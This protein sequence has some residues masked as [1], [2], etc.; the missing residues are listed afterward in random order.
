MRGWSGP[1]GLHWSRLRL[2]GG[3]GGGLPSSLRTCRSPLAPPTPAAPAL[4]LR[5]GL[6]SHFFRVLT[7]RREA[8]EL[9]AELLEAWG[10]R[11]ATEVEMLPSLPAAEYESGGRERERRSEERRVG[12]ECLRLCRSRW[13][14][15]H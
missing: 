8:G 12:K 15:Y 9:G 13:S 10:A 3:S 1:E 14:P 2:H 4:S 6:V 7:E 5:T 11:E